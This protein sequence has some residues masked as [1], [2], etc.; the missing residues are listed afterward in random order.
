MIEPGR[1]EAGRGGIVVAPH[2]LAAAAG[3]EALRDGANAVEAMVAMAA[4]IAVVYPHMN[5]L[6]GDGFWLIARPGRPPRVIE[7]CG[8]AGARA[9]QAWYRD[10]GWETI[11]G[12]GPAAALTV[13]GAVGGWRTALDLAAELG[14]RHP[15]DA[16]LAPA[17]ALAR[18]GFAVGSGYAEILAERRDELASAPGFAETF[19]EHGRADGAAPSPGALLRQPRLADTLDYLADAGLDEFYRGDVGQTLAAD[20]DALGSPLTRADL[21]R[22]RATVT[23]P[24]SLDIRGATLFNTPPP[25]QGL[26]SLIILGLFD[27]MGVREGEGFAHVHGLVEATKRAF[28]VR[29]RAVTDP[30]YAAD[31]IHR[32]LTAPWMDA[33]MRSIDAA[34]AAPWPQAAA[35][36]DTVWLGAVDKDGLAVSYIQSIYWEFGS[37]CVLPRTGILWQNRGCGFS[38]DPKAVNPLM[39]GRRPF[40]TL[41]PALARLKDGRVLVYGAM[42]GD[43][44]PQTQAALFTRIARF[45]L[46]PGAAVDAPRWLLGRTWGEETRTNLRLENRFPPELMRALRQAGHDVEVLD[47]AY[48]DLMGHAG[49]LLTR[50]DGYLE[51]AADP[52]SDGAAVVVG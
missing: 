47:T 21:E 44:Q 9:T 11:P 16:L 45:G 20:L 41:N 2:H 28:L 18:D 13:A 48:S 51:G 12:R 17:A 36:G 4:A 5:G 34:R 1:T 19:L 43:G 23:A 6:G 14:G 33:E 32:Y 22:F 37:G 39:P 30:A 26:A 3:A 27:R 31:D 42:G 46:A 29:D 10:K 52:R 50:P 15:L 49:A 25:T 7:A 40:H 35:P 8:P 38:L 24:L